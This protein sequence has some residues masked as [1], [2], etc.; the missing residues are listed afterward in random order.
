MA[1]PKGA[2]DVQVY[3]I[4]SHASSGRIVTFANES[5]VER[6]SWWIIAYARVKSRMRL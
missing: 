4:N 5:A 3:K 2:I 1:D 6:G